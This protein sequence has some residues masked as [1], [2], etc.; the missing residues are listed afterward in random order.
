MA[1]AVAARLHVL[2][3]RDA[4]TGV[5]IRR[6]PSRH[7]AVIGWDRARDRFAVGQW[8]YG[9]IY[10]R[11]CDLSPDG[12]HLLYFAMNGRWHT[13]V[14]GS[15]T[16]V[17]RAPH[18]K[19][20]TL[21]AK[22]DCWNGGGLFLSAREYWVNGGHGHDVL[23]DDSGLMRSRKYPWHESYGGECPGVYYVRLQRNGWELKSSSGAQT[24][25][26]TV[27][28]KRVGDRWVLRKLAHATIPHRIGRGCY[29]DEHQLCNARDQTTL[30]LPTWE[31]ADL[32]RR[33]LVWAEQGSLFSGYLGAK[34]LKD[35]E[36]LYD[37]NPLRFER[38]EA[39]Y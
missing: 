4:P 9:R 22:G 18:L 14:K 10:E 32:D 29:F 34:G 19:A 26:V 35:V 36:R 16:A 31:W 21:L 1:R 13:K 12:E 30:D 7:V 5:V 23:H 39:P 25:R 20:S 37:F 6:G 11:R 15:W 8:L 28:E 2:L 33:R 17:S 38:L 3:A 24:D 27:F